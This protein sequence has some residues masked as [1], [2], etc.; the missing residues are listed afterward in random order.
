[1]KKYSLLLF[2]LIV[3]LTNCEK[4]DICIEATTPNL[5]IKFYDTNNPETSKAV[6]SLTVTANEK[7]DIYTSVSLDSIVIPLNLSENSTTYKFQSG[8]KTDTIIF[9]YDRK[10]VFVSRSCGYKTVFENFT[11]QTSN[12]WIKSYVINNSTIENETNAHI[13]IYH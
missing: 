2:I 1:M 3:A 9:N 5:I 11:M 12:N 10:D 6:S 8:T 7:E 13:N 4:D